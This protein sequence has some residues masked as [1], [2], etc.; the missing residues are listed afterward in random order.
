MGFNS[1]FK[2]LNVLVMKCCISETRQRLKTCWGQYLDLIEIKGT[3]GKGQDAL[4]VFLVLLVSQPASSQPSTLAYDSKSLTSLSSGSF[5]VSL[6]WNYWLQS[7]CG[8]SAPRLACLCFSN[9]V[10][11]LY[12]KAM[13]S[14]RQR[15]YQLIA[16]KFGIQKY[17]YMFRPQPVDIYGVVTW[18]VGL[19][20]KY[21]VTLLSQQ[22]ALL[23]LLLLKLR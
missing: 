5:W 11:K 21:S 10:L 19:Y 6:E 20:G 18:L 4:T 3:T 13:T 9:A 17:C 1:V 2:G 14:Y 7:G 16:Q 15:C 8:Q 12:F 22:Y 23:I